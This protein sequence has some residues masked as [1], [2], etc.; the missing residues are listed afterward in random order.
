MERPVLPREVAVRALLESPA[1]AAARGS[2]PAPPP[3]GGKV[4]AQRSPDLTG[5]GTPIGRGHRREG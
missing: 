5:E 3:C 2:G 1:L 4:L